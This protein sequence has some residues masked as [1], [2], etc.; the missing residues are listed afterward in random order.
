MQALYAFELGSGEAKH[1]ID[2]TTVPYVV[3]DQDAWRRSE[4]SEA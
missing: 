4:V 3:Y 2:T 1:V